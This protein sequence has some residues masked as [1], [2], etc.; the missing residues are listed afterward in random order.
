MEI[1]KC[2]RGGKNRRQHALV[3]GKTRKWMCSEHARETYSL[4]FQILENENSDETGDRKSLSLIPNFHVGFYA[5]FDIER[6]ALLNPNRFE[7]GTV[8]KCFFIHFLER[9]GKRDFL[10]TAATEASSLNTLHAIWDFKA[11][12]IFAEPERLELESLQCGR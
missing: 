6:A 2:L 12:E 3:H 11:F 10:N 1:P 9:T 4:V 5:L 7:T 8:I